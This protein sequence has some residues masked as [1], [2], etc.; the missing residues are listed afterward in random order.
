M[1][2]VSVEFGA[3]DTGLENTLKT[4]QD[5]LVELDGELKSG[6]L[7]F[8]EINKK[9]REVAQA[10]KLHASL[11]GTKEKLDELGLSFRQTKPSVE[12]FKDTQ[13]SVSAETEKTATSFKTMAGEMFELRAALENGN[14]SADEFDKTLRR[15]NKLED[16]KQKMEDF[17]NSTASAGM[18][19]SQAAPKAD[20]LG[21]RTENAGNK[22]DGAAGIFES[23][24][25]KISAAFTVGNIA[26]QAFEKI[27]QT[28]FDIARA[29]AQGFSDALDLGGRLNELSVRTGEAAGKLLVLETAFKNSGIS[30]DQVGVAINKLQNFMADATAGGEKQTSAMNNLGISMSELNGKTPTQQMQVFAEKISAI[31][32]PTDRAAA[33]SEIFGDKLGGKLLP[34]LTDFSGN[35]DDARTKVGSLEQVMDENAATFDAAGETI[36]A[37]KGKMAAFAAGIMSETL[38]ALG[39]LG[40]AMQGVDAAGLGQQIGQQLNPALT[41]AAD[42]AKIV[43]ILFDRMGEATAGV[44]SEITKTQ[45]GSNFLALALVALQN[46]LNPAIGASNQFK[47]VLKLMGEESVSATNAQKDTAS[48][49]QATGEAAVEAKPKLDALP[50]A[51]EK[52]NLEFENLPKTIESTFPLIGEFKA[53]LDDAAPSVTAIG[54][55]TGVVKGD[56]S[57]ISSLTAQLPAQ[58]DAFTQS[59]V[60]TN[61]QLSLQPGIHAEI[62]QK[63]S[64]AQIKEEERRLALEQSANKLQASVELQI[65]LN[66]AIASGNVEEQARVQKLID[67]EAAQKRI[68]TLTDQYIASGLGKDEAAQLAT[69]LVNSQI[70]AD[71]V[72]KNVEGAKIELNNASESAKTVQQIIDEINQTEMDAPVKGLKERTAEAREKLGD[73]RDFIGE[74]LSNMS[75][76][77]IVEKL[78]LDTPALASSEDQLKEIE[79]FL[80]DLGN[81]DPANVTPEVDV[82]GSKDNIEQIKEALKETEG[83]DATPQI[84]QEKVKE[85]ASAARKNVEDDLKK[86]EATVTVKPKLDKEALQDEVDMAFASSKGT[87]HL[88][89]IDKLVETIKGFV[90]KIEGKLP[91][92]ALAY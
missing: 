38:P 63:L 3:K 74:D 77:S 1:A 54:A 87:E 4:I 49:I 84:D 86:V 75:L 6:T 76:S 30:A 72:K 48:A 33:A 7:S 37:V 81:E 66:E 56:F 61:E 15:L 9:M 11:G 10:E 92:Q 79:Q 50:V 18:A 34:V 41:A 62:F 51:G 55:E 43:T 44:T 67:A 71:N 46:Q 88:S 47:A 32:D 2:D 39:D 25:A 73:M 69:N 82:P 12:E 91:M 36:D 23:S 52:L 28:T 60:G 80:T 40:R 64:E 83:T 5:Q 53:G 45:E 14:L 24:F 16:I 70:A 58:N 57:E 42:A 20:E 31:K 21:Q 90:E 29:A 89:N 78:G 27:I 17:K 68:Q 8:D 85:Q 59:I 26:A 19:M 65:Q 22:A 35:L 13:K